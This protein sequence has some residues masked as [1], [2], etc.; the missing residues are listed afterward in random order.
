[1]PNSTAPLLSAD[2]PLLARYFELRS[3]RGR[4]SRYWKID[5]DA[6]DLS[7]VEPRAASAVLPNVT[8]RG[9]VV[10]DLATAKREHSAIF[11]AAFGS[12][13][14]AQNEKFAAL[15]TA[16]M[17]G[18]AF[19]YVPNDVCVDEPIMIEYDAHDCGIF[20]YT[21]V[22]AGRGAQATI[23]ERISG[24]SGAFVCGVSEIVTAESAHVTYASIQNLPDD[25]RIIFTRDAKPGRDAQVHWAVAELGAGLTVGGIDVAIE[26]TGVTAQITGLFFPSG[27]QHVDMKSTIDHTVGESQS[28]TLIKSAAIGNGQARYLGNIRIAPDAQ[29]SN[30]NLRDDA[31]LLSTKAHIDSIP[32]LEIAANDVKAYH[33][34]TVGALDEEQIFYMTSRGIAR[35]DAEKMIA[36]GFFEPAI[37]RFPGE[38]LREELRAALRAKVG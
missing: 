30:A 28:N 23:V 16:L 29:G 35:N 7:S 27:E 24:G 38:A 15:T 18:G 11:N 37:E 33:G 5:L 31:L 20:P 2:N 9:V 12:A 25:A 4:P 36:L 14:D 26:Q 6:L 17:E 19:V 22:V 21:L 13:I 10:C 1:M 34:A 32:A 8:A 3:N